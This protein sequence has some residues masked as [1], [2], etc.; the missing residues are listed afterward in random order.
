MRDSFIPYGAYW[1]TPFARWQGS[2]AHLHALEFAAHTAK[3]EL[4][5]RDIPAGVF[6]YA[7]LGTTVP[8]HH[9]FFGAPWLMG[10][11]PQGPGGTGAHEDWVL[12]NFG[13]DPY[14][15]VAMIDTAEDVARK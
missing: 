4:A 15:A 1:C 3:A 8:Q 6:D 5:R 13:H 11:N 12:D 2:F 10:T 14:A 7:V 9:S